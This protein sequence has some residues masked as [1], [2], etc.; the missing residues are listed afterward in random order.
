AERPL[1]TVAPAPDPLGR[2][3][4]ASLCDAHAVIIWSRARG[5]LRGAPVARARG[6]A[7]TGPMEER[8]H[9]PGRATEAF[10][11]T[12]PQAVVVYDPGTLDLLAVNPRAAEVF[13]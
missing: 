6:R 3:T 8:S 9:S 1:R 4:S 5:R 13:G 7:G 11:R 2:G 10:F 12:H